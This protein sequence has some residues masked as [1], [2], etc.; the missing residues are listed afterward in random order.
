MAF[1]YF[2]P[3]PNDI[4]VGDC[5]IR[6]ISKLT[7]KPWDDVYLGVVM[8]GFTDKDMPSSNAVWDR[9][10]RGLGYNKFIIPNT[11]PGCYTVSDFADDH[12]NGKYLLC[13]GSHVIAVE[14]GDYYD[15]YDSGRKTPQYFYTK[16]EV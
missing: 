5:V 7:N 8:Q 11:C 2:N 16:Q 3:N 15:S 12:P 6:G 9:Y 4:L 10:L 14:N 13:T 1:E